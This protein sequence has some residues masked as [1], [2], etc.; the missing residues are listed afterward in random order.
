MRL[1]DFRLRFNVPDGYRIN[2]AE[3]RLELLVLP[4]NERITLCSAPAG[5]P[6]E[7]CNRVAVMGGPFPS[8]EQAR[9][10]AERSKWA[11]LYWAVERQWG[12]DFG[13]GKPRGGF[14]K[15]ALADLEQRLG[16]HVRNDI[17]GVDVY[18]HV[19]KVAFA[20]GSAQAVSLENA[21]RLAD[22]F[23][24]EYPRSRHLIDK[25]LLAFEM[26]SSSFFDASL[27]SR[28]VT[29]VTAVEALLERRER[30][31]TVDRL[32]EQFKDSVQMSSIDEPTKTSIIGGL[33][34]LKRESI[35][36]AGRLLADRLIPDETFDGQSSADLFAYCYSVR[37]QIL[38]SGKVEEVSV[39]M[40][41]LV[42]VTR[43]LV[44]K[45]LLAAL[46][47]APQDDIPAG[48]GD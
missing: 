9:S 12:V 33:E 4:T 37:S 34:N 47:E 30:C 19:E 6:I 38:H 48:H 22:A 32:V 10:A 28:F 18:E 17:H 26:Y 13:G 20:G 11:L 29:L 16:H 39:D 5:R 25:H 35:T 46:N 1:Y 3:R 24:R 23:Q 7:D 36:Q 15:A 44:A 45:L 8:E 31:T 40:P 27:R 41:H 43:T 14:T 21:A 42:G 2:S